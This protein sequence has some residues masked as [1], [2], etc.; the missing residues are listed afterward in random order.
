LPTV[1]TAARLTRPD[2]RVDSDTFPTIMNASLK[3]STGATFDEQVAWARA[4]LK[5]P[6]LVRLHAS[7]NVPMSPKRFA[8]NIVRSFGN[9]RLRIPPDPE[10]AY[11]EFCGPG[12][13]AEV[14]AVRGSG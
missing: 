12:T 13:P 1:W 10:V 3:P 7:A 14:N 5:C 9:T 6:S 11:H 2:P 4:A 8:T